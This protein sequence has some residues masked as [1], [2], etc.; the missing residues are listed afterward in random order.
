MLILTPGPPRAV[1]C[2]SKSKIAKP[3]RA[4]SNPVSVRS[5]QAKRPTAERTM[6][7]YN[8]ISGLENN[9]FLSSNEPSNFLL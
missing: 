8:T 3:Q 4:P 2:I 7:K 6:Q 1:V 9:Y 5:S